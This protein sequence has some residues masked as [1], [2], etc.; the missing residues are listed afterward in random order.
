MR[1][2]SGHAVHGGA[3]TKRARASMRAW[4]WSASVALLVGAGGC[5]PTRFET[6]P[7][8]PPPLIE[9]IPIAI[10]VHLPLEFREMVYE[11]KRASGGGSYSIGLGKAQSAGFLRILEAMFEKVVVVSS[12][13]DGRARSPRGPRRAA[14]RAR[15]LC[16]RDADGL[17]HAGL[18]GEPAL[19]DPAF[20]SGGE[21]RGELDVHGLRFAAGERVPGQGRRGAA[22]RDAA[23][24][25]RRGRQARGGVSRTGDRARPGCPRDDPAAR[26]GGST[27]AA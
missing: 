15:G 11:E 9:K 4:A 16:L 12:V 8:V 21:T 13:A 5:A 6:P 25:A 3:A 24:D 17:R 22:G 2:D 20:F 7:D 23:R 10:G 19:H 1:Q 27:A 26:R 18:R 14:A